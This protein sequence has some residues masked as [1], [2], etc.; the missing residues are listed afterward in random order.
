MVHEADVWFEVQLNIPRR[1]RGT[2]KRGPDRWV[3]AGDR[4]NDMTA[5]TRESAEELA[6]ETFTRP[7]TEWRVVRRVGTAG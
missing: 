5:D 2:A 3:Y 7:E 6:R 1:I 4:Y